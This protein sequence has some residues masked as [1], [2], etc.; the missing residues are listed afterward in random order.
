VREAVSLQP[1]YPLVN[2]MRSEVAHCVG[3]HAGKAFSES[4]VDRFGRPHIYK[5]QQAPALIRQSGNEPG[6]RNP[7]A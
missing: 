5:E 3:G 4:H 7:C 6:R 1:A 2:I